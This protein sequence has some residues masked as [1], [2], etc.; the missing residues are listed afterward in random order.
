MPKRD[1]SGKE[2]RGSRVGYRVA[3]VDDDFVEQL[4]AFVDAADAT[5]E[6]LLYEAGDMQAHESHTRHLDVRATEVYLALRD[7]SN[8]V[9][10]FLGALQRAEAGYVTILVW[11]EGRGR[12][13]KVLCV[14]PARD[15]G[16]RLE[17]AKAAV[18][19]SGTLLPMEYHRK[20][21]AAQDDDPT[22]YAQSSF[23][24]GRQQVLIGSDVSARYS[25]RGPELYARV[26]K[27]L[28]ALVRARPGN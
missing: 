21:L 7:A 17:Q 20:L 27:Y 6:Q 5:L 1:G 23:D 24:Y 13:L 19:F 28:V 18:F 2:G 8:A 12:K 10:S 16:D 15:L 3:H 11:D 26:A 22:L 14:N 4:S 9:R 25:R